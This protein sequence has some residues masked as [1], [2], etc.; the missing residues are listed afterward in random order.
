[1][2]ETLMQSYEV[3]G[4]NEN[5]SMREVEQ[6]YHD[7]RDLYGEESLATYSLLEY[8]D[9][10]EKLESLQEAYETILSEKVVKSDQPVPP[11]EAPIVCKLEP[12]EVSADPSEKPGLYLQQLREIRGMSLRDV[13]ERTKIG[14]FHLECIEQQRFDRLPAPVYLRGFVREFARTVGA[15]DPDAVVE[16]LLA[17]YREE[18]DD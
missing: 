1:M 3:L 15:D 8:A 10:Q 5:A 18:V 6:A 12:V 17:R 7:L 16:S 4:L 2:E 9:R 11:R 13:S 14:G